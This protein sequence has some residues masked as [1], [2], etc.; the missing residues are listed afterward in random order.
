MSTNRTFKEGECVE[1]K[2]ALQEI[3]DKLESVKR[4]PPS[5]LYPTPPKEIPAG[6]S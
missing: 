1:M 4:R 6:N 2:V 3:K 5:N